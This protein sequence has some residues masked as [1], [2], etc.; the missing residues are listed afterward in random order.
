MILG[1][2]RISKGEEQ[3]SK[4]QINALKEAKVQ[5]IYDEIGSGGRW[6]RPALHKMIEQLR[7]D[8]VVVV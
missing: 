3:T 7:E 2:S 8:D 5:K 6:N 4:L 1:Y